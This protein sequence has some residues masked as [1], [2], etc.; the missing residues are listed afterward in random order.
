MKKRMSAQQLAKA[1]PDSRRKKG[2][3]RV[4]KLLRKQSAIQERKERKK[5]RKRVLDE[6]P[7]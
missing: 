4:A 6:T 1:L 5:E 2:A 3:L 7:A